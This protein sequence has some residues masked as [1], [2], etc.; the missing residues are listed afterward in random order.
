[1]ANWTFGAA[2]IA[3]ASLAPVKKGGSFT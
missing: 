3:I 1:M 2:G